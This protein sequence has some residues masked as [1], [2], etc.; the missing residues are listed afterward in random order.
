MALWQWT[1]GVV[2]GIYGGAE[3][4]RKYEENDGRERDGDEARTDEAR[5]V[6]LVALNNQLSAAEEFTTSV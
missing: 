4:K 3:R 1:V 6:N 5:L 2:A